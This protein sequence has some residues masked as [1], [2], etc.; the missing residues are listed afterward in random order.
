MDITI[1]GLQTIIV[2]SNLKSSVVQMDTFFTD[3]RRHNILNNMLY[4]IKMYVE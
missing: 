1:Q 3:T 4:I 2:Y